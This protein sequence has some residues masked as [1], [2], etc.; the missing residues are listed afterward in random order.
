MSFNHSIFDYT[1]LGMHSVYRDNHDEIHSDNS[2]EIEI[3]GTILSAWLFVLIFGIVIL[4]YAWAAIRLINR[5]E[6]LPD[7]ARIFGVIG[8]IPVLPFGPIVTL[9][10]VYAAAPCKSSCKK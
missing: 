7:W 10:I 9:I 2:G 1:I 8:L 4:I 6:I 5:W 3:Y